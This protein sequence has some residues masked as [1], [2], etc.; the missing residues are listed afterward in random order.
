MPLRRAAALAAALSVLPGCAAKYADPPE[1][2][3]E[4]WFDFW[5][6]RIVQG[7]DANI[8][9]HGLRLASNDARSDTKPMLVK[10]ASLSDCSDDVLGGWQ[11]ETYKLNERVKHRHVFN[12]QRGGTY[13]MCFKHRNNWETAANQLSVVQPSSTLPIYGYHSCANFIAAKPSVACGCFYRHI[14]SS[15]RGGDLGTEAYE[16]P[17]WWPVHDLI[18]QDN[19]VNQ[20]CCAM[21]AKHRGSVVNQVGYCHNN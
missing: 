2:T 14:Q 17:L 21:S 4:S 9:F 5:P 12:V 15:D 13:Y 11:R 20:G 1:L 16:F 19:T 7:E 3:G 8:T 6:R 18:K 10:L